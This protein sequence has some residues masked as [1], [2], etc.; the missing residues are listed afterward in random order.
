ML[1]SVTSRPTL[2]SIT[3]TP[4]GNLERNYGRVF[5]GSPKIQKSAILLPSLTN[6]V[7]CVSPTDFGDTWSSTVLSTLR[8]WRS[9]ASF[10]ALATSHYWF[11][12]SPERLATFG[13]E[14]ALRSVKRAHFFPSL[15]VASCMMMLIK[16]FKRTDSVRGLIHMGAQD[17]LFE[18]GESKEHL[19]LPFLQNRSQNQRRLHFL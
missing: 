5:N 8:P 15:G 14:I 9:S 11:A 4:P 10:M 1:I 3:S 13:R 6:S 16:R 17:S 7:Y 18:G 12:T 2:P 19:T